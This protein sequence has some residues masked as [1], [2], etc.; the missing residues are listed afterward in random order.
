[1]KVQKALNETGKA[2]LGLECYASVGSDGLILYYYDKK[3]S[4]QSHPVGYKTLLSNN[5]QPYHEEEEIR[6][7]NED[8]AWL[9]KDTGVWITHRNAN[10]EI[11]LISSHSLGS[12]RLCDTG[13]IHNKNGWTRIEP[14]VEDKSIERKEIEGVRWYQN[15]DRCIVPEIDNK[16]ADSLL[17]KPPMKMILVMQKESI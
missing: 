13:A 1:M 15:K 14:P 12:I 9:S 8:E 5:W 11:V 3:T 17:D 6:P 2:E 7:E 10:L 4:K 16:T